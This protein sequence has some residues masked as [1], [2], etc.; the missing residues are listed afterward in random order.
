MKQ[1]QSKDSLHSTISE[2]TN[3]ENLKLGDQVKM[4]TGGRAGVVA[5][6]GPTDFQAGIWIGV[7]LERPEGKNNGSV[8]GRVYFKCQDKFGVFCRPN[9]LVKLNTQS[10][11]Q[12]PL[13]QR[14]QQ[15][16]RVPSPTN[17]IASSFAPSIAA[18]QVGG[19]RDHS[20]FAQEYG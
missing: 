2:A 19:L 20:P 8:D 17:S 14:S 10:A 9:N 16:R 11:I 15:H 6:V 5:F 13:A 4:K 18:S 7:I 1:A 3:N 12:S